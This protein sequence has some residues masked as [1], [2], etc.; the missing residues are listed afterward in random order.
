MLNPTAASIHSANNETRFNPLIPRRHRGIL[1]LFPPPLL[2]YRH[3]NPPSGLAGLATIHGCPRYAQAVEVRELRPKIDRSRR[4]GEEQ[5]NRPTPG[6]E[7]QCWMCQR[8]YGPQAWCRGSYSLGLP[9]SQNRRRSDQQTRTRLLLS[10]ISVRAVRCDR[11]ALPGWW[12]AAA[13]KKPPSTG[14]V[15]LTLPGGWRRS[16]NDCAERT[17][18]E[19]ACAAELNANS[20]RPVDPEFFSNRQRLSGGNR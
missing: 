2:A 4:A 5:P 11:P 7:V 15:P 10:G 12:A 17:R 9:A 8:T 19:A 18:E 3:R 16:C 20:A 13:K 6:P 1:P 14:E